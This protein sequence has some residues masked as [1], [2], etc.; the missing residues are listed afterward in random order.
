MQNVGKF[1]LIRLGSSNG[2]FLNKRRAHQPVRLCDLDR[3]VIGDTEFTFRQPEAIPSEY[4][5]AIAQ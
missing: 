2:T 3:I 1:W 4:Q 5:A